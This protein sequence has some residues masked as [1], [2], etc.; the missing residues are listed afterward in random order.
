M[1]SNSLK[2]TA[3]IFLLFTFLIIISRNTFGQNTDST[4]NTRTFSGNFSVTN[5][6]FSNIPTFSLGKPAIIFNLVAGGK[7][8]S[9]EPEI[10]FS[11]EGK[12]WSF[13]FW[14]RQKMV[15]KPKYQMTYGIHPG[16]NFRYQNAVI[17]GVESIYTI[18]RLYIT[19]ELN[20]NF[21]ITKNFATSFYYSYGHG[22][23]VGTVKHTHYVS[24]R[25][26]ISNL[27]IAKDVSMRIN[28]QV[29][30]L[31]TG[32]KNGTYFASNFG[33]YKKNWP[34]WIGGIINQKLK[35]DIVS[36]DFN[37]NISLNY[38]FGGNYRPEPAP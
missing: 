3:I 14:F 25:A 24:F 22:V 26:A 1:P 21:P 38:M 27:K 30:F 28:P 17:N 15:L 13:L 6:G 8:T 20:Q 11:L 12:P 9:F 19:Q 5:N 35:S 23:D 31:N 34:V 32:Y 33:V 2:T 37:W 36:K 10:R 4:Q 29:F 16:L 18:E 7:R